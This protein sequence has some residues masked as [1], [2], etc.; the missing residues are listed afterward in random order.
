MCQQ[1]RR[2]WNRISNKSSAIMAVNVFVRMLCILVICLARRVFKKT[3]S[4]KWFVWKVL[5][6]RKAKYILLYRSHSRRQIHLIHTCH[7][8]AGAN[9]IV[10]FF[11]LLSLPNVKKT[12][13]FCL[14][15][16]KAKTQ[17]NTRLENMFVVE[18]HKIWDHF[19]MLK[20]F[21]SRESQL[22]FVD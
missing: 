7:V 11:F 21:H 3:H 4:M 15:S 22:W 6:W 5:C 2:I 16:L 1:P 12:L 19:W 18:R 13:I 9:V 10:F 8:G 20:F 14:I 17:R